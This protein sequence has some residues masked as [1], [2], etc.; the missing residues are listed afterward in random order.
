M[1]I[2]TTSSSSQSIKISPR[3]DATS[4]TLTLKNKSTRKTSTVSVTKTTEGEFMKLTGTF[5]LKEGEQYSFTV[6]DGS[7]IIYR[8]LIFCTDQTELD[9]YFIN[10][11]EYVSEDSYDNDFVFI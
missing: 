9:K 7:D 3:K 6:K 10:K 5:S 2:L 1:E 11:D 8:G 4:P